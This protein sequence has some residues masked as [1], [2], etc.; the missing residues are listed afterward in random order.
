M[1]KDSTMLPAVVRGNRALRGV[2]GGL[3]GTTVAS[4]R[5]LAGLG[6]TRLSSEA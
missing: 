5:A 3:A 6:D 4:P 2:A 1:D